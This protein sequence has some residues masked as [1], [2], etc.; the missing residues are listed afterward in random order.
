ML[1]PLT[2]NFIST[3]SLY[4]WGGGPFKAYSDKVWN[5]DLT[6]HL[7]LWFLRKTKQ[8]LKVKNDFGDQIKMSRVLL[9]TEHNSLLIVESLYITR[10]V[11][12]NHRITF[13]L[14][15]FFVYF[16]CFDFGN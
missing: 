5:S 2:V 10:T 16:V 14:I 15:M 11:P 3:L 9:R 8:E 7:N 12:F 1:M 13:L 4:V 6:D